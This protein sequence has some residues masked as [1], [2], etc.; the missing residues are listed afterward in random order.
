MKFTFILGAGS[1]IPFIRMNNH[2][3]LSTSYLSRCL[4][5]INI[6]KEVLD[7]FESYYKNYYKRN[8]SFDSNTAV[9]IV[10]NTKQ[11][12]SNQKRGANFERIIYLID[13]ISSYLTDQFQEENILINFFKK[14]ELLI[15]KVWKEIDKESYKYFSYLCREVL[16]RGILK[17]WNSSKTKNEI[18]LVRDFYNRISGEVNIYTLNYDPLLYE[19]LIENFLS[20]FSMGFKPHYGYNRVF[21][22]KSFLNAKNI[23]AFIHGHIGF[24]PYQGSMGFENNY[25]KACELRMEGVFKNIFGDS[26]EE[27][28]YSRIKYT[29]IGYIGDVHYNTWLITGINKFKAFDDNPFACYMLR[30]SKDIV[31]S[32]YI[33][34]IGTNMNDRHLM[35]FLKNTLKVKE[36][37]II[38]VTEIKENEDINKFIEKVICGKYWYWID[39]PLTLS[40]D[41]MDKDLPKWFQVLKN[42]LREKKWGFITPHIMIYAKGVEDFYKERDL[43]ELWE[44]IQKERIKRLWQSK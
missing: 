38:F 5:D 13:K 21:D 12:I 39:E 42:M 33:I 22:E 30:F 23:I 40:L 34:V 2:T 1:S 24:V 4:E 20:N 10:K 16:T 3:V 43:E 36:K 15:D 35:L 28:F 8:L 26:E 9:A 41:T 31:E 11:V 32:D 44:K 18:K 37:K 25:L 17:L 14:N 27:Q 29:N 19:A 7:S 6:W